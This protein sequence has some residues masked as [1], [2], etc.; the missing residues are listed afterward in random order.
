MSREHLSINS[1]TCPTHVDTERLPRKRDHRDTSPPPLLYKSYHPTQSD[2]LSPLYSSSGHN[3]NRSSPAIDAHSPESSSSMSCVSPPNQD[4]RLAKYPSHLANQYNDNHY[5]Y[6]SKKSPSDPNSSSSSNGNYSG[7]Q[8]SQEPMSLDERRKR[9]KAASAKYR[10]KKQIQITHM[11][12]EINI[13]THENNLLQKKLKQICDDNDMLRAKIQSMQSDQE[14]ADGKRK[15]QP[16][17]EH[18]FQSPI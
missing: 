4:M 12:N 14:P 5:P 10:A 8:T 17:D 15:K 9:N 2:Q 13:L 3:R 11:S 18:R 1:L 6:S 7:G 16:R